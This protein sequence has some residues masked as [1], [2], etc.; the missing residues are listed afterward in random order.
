MTLLATDWIWVKVTTAP[1]AS[2]LHPP[3]TPPG[4]RLSRQEVKIKTCAGQLQPRRA[5]EVL[6]GESAVLGLTTAARTT[7][8]L[9]CRREASG[10]R[11]PKCSRADS[12]LLLMERAA[13]ASWISW[14]RVK[15]QERRRPR[16]RQSH[17]VH[18]CAERNLGLIIDD[19][20]PNEVLA[21]DPLPLLIARFLRRSFS[22]E[23][24]HD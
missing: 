10:L 18:L 20:A 8:K 2:T 6:V 22:L 15:T 4:M 1:S 7:L 9:K 23:G 14:T 17:S 5:C 24:F 11:S 19:A 3:P 13:S 12:S 16:P 21:R